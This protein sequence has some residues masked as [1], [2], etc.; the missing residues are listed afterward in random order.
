M[1]EMKCPAC[2]AGGRVP[3]EK[4]G[5]RLVCRKC[6]R[7]FYLTPTHQAILGEPPAPKSAGKNANKQRAG[8]D[9]SSAG[10]SLGLDEF[11]GKL[12]KV[13]LPDPRI[14]AVLAVLVLVGGA[15]YWIFSRQ[16]LEVRARIVADAIKSSDLKQII[17]IS[18]PGTENDL[19]L[20]YAD[21]YKQYL[22]L[23]L[24]LGQDAGVTIQKTG[25]SRGGTAMVVAQFARSGAR[26]DSPAL[27][28]SLQPIPSL[29]NIKSTLE[30]P[31]FF[32]VDGYGNW[33]LDGKR[34]AVGSGPPAGPQ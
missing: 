3:N 13:K 31:L 11:A 6:L 12:G 1:I 24:I 29:S 25:D 16:S 5:V 22:N 7:V 28:E 17:D 23:K 33:S 9:Q 10:I 19:I 34:T 32:V 18:V 2:H 27:A 26:P 15:A 21:V 30:V 4:V 14:I 20:W 8:R